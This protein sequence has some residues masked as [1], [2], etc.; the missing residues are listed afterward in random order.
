MSNNI[1][2][3]CEKKRELLS[4][5]KLVQADNDLQRLKILFVSRTMFG[6]EIPNF[7]EQFI[8]ILH[9]AFFM[10]DN[11]IIES[12]SMKTYYDKISNIYQGMRFIPRTIQDYDAPTSYVTLFSQVSYI[13]SHI[14]KHCMIGTING[15]YLSKSVKITTRDVCSDQLVNRFIRCYL[16]LFHD[17]NVEYE[18]EILP[19]I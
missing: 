19:K 12:K 11:R 9:F 17:R 2:E 15:S 13:E 5:R 6:Y 14:Y 10:D 3:M 16:D 18:K 8:I 1:Y 7:S 4:N